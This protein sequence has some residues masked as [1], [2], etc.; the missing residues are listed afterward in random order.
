MDEEEEEEEEDDDDEEEEDDDEEE[1]EEDEEEEEED[2]E[3]EGEEEEEPLRKKVKRKKSRAKKK[4]KLPKSKRPNLRHCL[5]LLKQLMKEAD[6][7][8]FLEPVD[9]EGLGLTDYYE[10][11]KHPMDL[12]T[13]HEALQG[14]KIVG[15]DNIK[16]KSPLDFK[17]DVQLVWKNCRSYNDQPEDAW[18]RE[19]SDNCERSFDAMWK[20]HKFDLYYEMTAENEEEEEEEEE[21]VVVKPSRKLKKKKKKK[22]K[23]DVKKRKREKKAKKVKQKKLKKGPHTSEKSVEGDVVE[24]VL[25]DEE[26]KQ[27][28]DLKPNARCPVCKVQ[29]KGSCGTE[30]SPLRCFRRQF[31]GLPYTP[32]STSEMHKFASM[33]VNRQKN[34]IPRTPKKTKEEIR[35]IQL[36][37]KITRKKEDAEKAFVRV[38]EAEKE[39]LVLEEIVKAMEVREVCC[40]FFLS[41]FL[42]FFLLLTLYSLLSDGDQKR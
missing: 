35:R 22:K 8:P 5:K 30:T 32:L 9:A 39:L 3:D 16:Y 20:E 7:E 11:V 28:F 6:A 13:I 23:A 24:K 18:I 27:M 26:V 19:M 4:L 40:H 41:F 33:V 10:E 1:E 25:T 31:E 36:D 12:G 17:Q 42:S 14:G 38:G 37:K 15:W 34:K 29:K 2:E 21:E